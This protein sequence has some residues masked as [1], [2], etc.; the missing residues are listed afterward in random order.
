MANADDDKWTLLRATHEGSPIL[1][2]GRQFADSVDRAAFPIRLNVF[3]EMAEPDENGLASPTEV[4]ALETFEDRLV[5]A[6]DHDGQSLLSVVITGKGQREWVFHTA[7]P[8]EFVRRLTDMPQ[9]EDR[10]PIEIE[11][12]EDPDWEYF[13]AVT[14][15]A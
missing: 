3:W 9:E 10:Y 4:V 2:R 1:I 5:Q 6:V 7:D 11:G 14:A 12:G 13:E 8:D 15:T